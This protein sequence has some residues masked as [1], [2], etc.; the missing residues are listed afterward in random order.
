MQRRKTS[1]PRIAALHPPLTTR[2][3]SNRPNFACSRTLINP[4]ADLPSNLRRAKRRLIAAVPDSEFKITNR[5]YSHLTFFIRSCSSHFALNKPDS[6]RQLETIRNARN[7]FK[8]MQITFSNRPKKKDPIFPSAFT[9]HSIS[10][11]SWYR[12]EFNISPTKQRTEALS[13]RS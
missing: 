8:I 13:N 6:N 3:I 5:N 2:A 4:P 11:R 7:P 12:L 10:N 1:W 9:N